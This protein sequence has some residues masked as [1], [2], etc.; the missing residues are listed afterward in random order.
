METPLLLPPSFPG[1]NKLHHGWGIPTWL[2]L[3]AVGAPVV[4]ALP[5]F[6]VYHVHFPPE[7]E[8]NWGVHIQWGSWVLVLGGRM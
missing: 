1:R 6:L 8:P 5:Y 4:L 3:A 7:N 2:G